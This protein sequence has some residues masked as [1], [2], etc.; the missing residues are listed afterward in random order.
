[1]KQTLK[2]TDI[3]AVGFML[4]AFF[5]GAGNIIFPPLAGQLAGE[6]LM[7]AMFGFLLTAVG[8][9]LITIVAIAV[10]GGTWDHLTQDLPKKAAVVMAALIFIII[11]PAFAAPRTGLVA[12]E[13]AVKPFFIEASQTNLTAFSVLF[14]VVAMLF[15]W[16]QGRLIDL[17]GKVLTPV[18]FLGLI[19]LA[20][21]VFIDPQGEMIGATGEYLT[22]PLTKGFLEGYNTMDTFASLM[23]GMLMV[24][25][26]RGKGITERAATTKYLIFAGCIAAAGLAFVYI[27]LFYLGATSAT[28]AAGADNGGLVLS[29]YVQ[30]LF[31]P[32]GQIVL[33]VIVLLACL[34]TAIGLISACSDFFSSKTSLSYK[35]WVLI[36]GSVCALVAN[37]G[38]AQLISLSV[39]VLFALYPVAIALVALTFVRSKLPNTRF[40]Y[41]AVLL[42]SLLFALLDAAKVAGMDVSAF[43][44]LPLFEIG[45]GWVLPTLAAIICMFFI[46]KP[47]NELVE[48]TA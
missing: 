24:D 39:P 26:L 40:A 42:V 1:M 20:L 36:N 5:L 29:Q 22:Q 9:P 32:Y 3:I 34:T 4:F 38:L 37:V 48:E 47:Q 45:M 13:M 12:Y 8:L 7:P 43:N 21:A 15:S 17:I 30:A 41:R 14:F 27:S 35:H 10:A 44:M 11:G 18:L 25:A 33:S 28:V 6:N 31:G 16:F 23:F 2:L 19:V 46:S